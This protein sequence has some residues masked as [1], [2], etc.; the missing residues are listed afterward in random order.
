MEFYNLPITQNINQLIH[1]SDTHIRTG[2]IIQSRYNEYLQVFKN[3]IKDIKNLESVK[4]NSAI[5][6]ITG[7]LFHAKSK[8]ESS[9]IILFN[10]LL[11]SLSQLAPVLLILGN[12]DYVQMKSDETDMISAFLKYNSINNVYYL[13]KTGYYIVNNIGFGLVSVKDTLENGNTS[14]QIEELPIFPN[15][16]NFPDNI[17]IK[18]ALFHGTIINSVMDNYT[19]STTGYPIDWFNGYDIT[20]L[21][22]IHLRSLYQNKK[23]VNLTDDIDFND[24]FTMGYS[25]SLIQQNFGE[26]IIDHGYLIWDLE[27]S[28]VTTHNIYNEYGFLKLQFKNNE[29]ISAYKKSI[30]LEILINNQYFPKNIKIRIIGSNTFENINLLKEILFKNNIK[31]EFCS[32]LL[33]YVDTSSRTTANNQLNMEI[34]DITEFNSQNTWFTFI[35][36]KGL[37]NNTDFD[38]KKHIIH[39][40]LF[41]IQTD[42]LYIQDKI[43]KK[44]LD[45]DTA[46]NKFKNT[47]DNTIIKNTIHLCFIKFQWLLCFDDKSYFNFDDI[48]SNVA[49]ISALNGHG[50]SSF[51]E[52]ICLALFGQSIPSR[53]NK[54]ISASI[55]SKQKPEKAHSY[56]KIVFIIDNIKYLLY[57]L[58]D[59]QSTDKDKLNIRTV[60]LSILNTDGTSKKIFSGT[61]AVNKWIDK[62]IGDINNFLL[63]CMITQSQDQDFFSIKPE[64]QIQLLDKSLKFDSVNALTNLLKIVSNSYKYL[65]DH[66]DT[67][68]EN[69]TINIPTENLDEIIILKENDLKLIINEYDTIIENWH[70]LNI[71]DFKEDSEKIN[72]KINSINNELK[73]LPEIKENYDKLLILKGSIQNNISKINIP[74]LTN[75]EK[76]IA[77]EN[78]LEI[79]TNLE[80]EKI[81]KPDINIIE[82]NNIN[83]QEWNTKTKEF[84][85]NLNSENLDT[86]EFNI[87][88][89]KQ[90]IQFKQNQLNNIIQIEYLSIDILPLKIKYNTIN[91]LEYICKNNPL[92]KPSITVKQLDKNK[93]ILI[94]EYQLK[95]INTPWNSKKENIL[96][97]SFQEFNLYLTELITEQNN[98]YTT[99]SNINNNINDIE[100]SIYNLENKEQNIIEEINNLNNIFQ[101][102][103]SIDIIDNNINNIKKYTQKYDNLSQNIQK[104]NVFINTYNEYQ[105]MIIKKNNKI[106]ELNETLEQ[107]N[108][109]IKN[110][111]FN[112][113]CEACKQNPLRIQY[114][115]IIEQINY[116]KKE[117]LTLEYKQ[118]QHLN[119]KDI[120][121]K[122][123]KLEK[124]N[125]K[126][127][128]YNEEI[129]KKKYYENLLIQWEKYNNYNILKNSLFNI[130]NKL[131]LDRIQIKNIYKEKNELL[132]KINKQCDLIKNIEYIIEHYQQ[133][134]DTYNFITEQYN[135]WN[136]YN[137]NYEIHQDYNNWILFNKQK[138]IETLN[139]SLLE[140]NNSLDLYI[141]KQE[142]NK[143]KEYWNNIIKNNNIL[144][145]KLNQWNEWNDKYNKYKY[146]LYSNDLQI[147]EDKIN[148][149]QK[150]KIFKKNIEYWTNIYNIKPLYNKKNQLKNIIQIKSNELIELKEK[151]AIIRRDLQI[152][153][154][155]L[156][157]S[158]QLQSLIEYYKNKYSIVSILSTSFIDYRT[159]LYKNKVLPKIISYTNILVNSVCENNNIQLDGYINNNNHIS[160]FIK[161]G[162]NTVSIEKASGFQKFMIGIAIRISLSYIGA[163]TV[164]CKQLFIDEGFVACDYKH[165]QKIPSFI[166]SLLNLYDS[167]LI[168]SHL[169]TIKES[170]DITI[171]IQRNN[172]IS[173]IQYGYNYIL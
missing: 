46:I 116:E 32:Q 119:N 78:L 24:T 40:E 79:I 47:L 137:K 51:L 42:N 49:L 62:N 109:S 161:D 136:D 169:D 108:N 131:K 89:I 154:N 98:L 126:F 75:Q 140:L 95:I 64:Q 63:S 18:I 164:L 99:Q 53:Y 111:P 4:N 168:V 156:E 138:E 92:I 114:N 110:I 41:K 45:I 84:Y 13:E 133:W 170:T 17:R 148:I 37:L 74:S 160:W 60:H 76:N 94:N 146:I 9:G 134:I 16:M 48:N 8:C 143:E 20:L 150:I 72:N 85:L 144:I 165:I 15:P 130:R 50:K 90:N 73:Q 122:N 159:W 81:I 80:S 115:N 113:S 43:I 153:I 102:S 91:N 19:T 44:N 86:I 68:N 5:I 171:E 151:N 139:N 11:T 127:K 39:P 147:I 77:S 152:Y 3:L 29:W 69:N 120:Q 25:G 70:Q 56:T 128:L 96:N 54:S 61:T 6:I 167:I 67:Y 103:I 104:L 35:E 57:R 149:I 59:Y 1:I 172:S 132:I 14:G 28:K 135:L 65:L 142:Y 88:N 36:E 121:K 33:N 2:D 38:W 145:Q 26:H 83:I 155:N 7:D 158:K 118:K 30:K 82:T 93:E 100:T 173:N 66:L 34:D 21:G 163:S 166:H 124:L 129:E 101:P 52:I 105:Q 107:I 27:K 23:M 87:N 12:H 55:I 162:L 31:Y 10:F 58:Y 97:N 71:E 141:K 112:N 157:K 125:N 123:N 22:D 106:I 117:L